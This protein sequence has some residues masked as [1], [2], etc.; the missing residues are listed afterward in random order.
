[1]DGPGFESW[2]EQEILSSSKTMQVDSGPIHPAI[3]WVPGLYPGSESGQ[4]M[5]MT[6]YLQLVLRLRM[7]G[8]VPILP[9]FTIL[10]LQYSS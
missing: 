4:G 10:P 9:L 5:N 2:Q 1:M 6:I 8:A 3:Q 7:R